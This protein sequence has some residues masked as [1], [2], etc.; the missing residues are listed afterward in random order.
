LAL[1]LGIGI[2]G[3]IVFWWLNWPLAW[4][5][6][7]MLATTLAAMAGL[8]IAVPNTL[9]TP[10]L[11]LLGVLL[12]SG[13]SADLVG[14]LQGWLPTLLSLP[15][16]VA[17]VTWAGTVY[18]RKVA[19]YDN[20]TAL[21]AG[22]PGGFGEM[23]LLG[24]QAGADVRRIALNH[25]VRI[26]LI[27]LA[28]PLVVRAFGMDLPAMPMAEAAVRWRDIIAL[29]AAAA[30][31]AW[32]A[33]LARLP[34][35]ALLGGMLISAL[36]HATGVLHGAPPVFVIA[37]AQLVIGCSIGCRFAGFR[38]H[39]VLATMLV[40]LGLTVVLALVSLAVAV[41]IHLLTGTD[42][43]PLM[44]ALMPGGVAE[45]SVIALAL[46]IDPAFVAT[47]HIVRIALIVAAAPFVFRRLGKGTKKDAGPKAGV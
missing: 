5:L 32:L 4:L 16:Y 10:M 20:R 19:R 15:A 39:D 18:L 37:T 36:G 2:I 28:V 34:A 27:V 23:V 38:L 1:A 7:P 29:L 21:F 35:P 3:G 9:R 22:T 17:V 25:A 42:P 12:G 14:E 47:H 45:M 44:L 6:G 41:A 40:G 26:L 8:Q 33:G 11:A 43:V 46:G 13:F 31:G 24:D 30:L